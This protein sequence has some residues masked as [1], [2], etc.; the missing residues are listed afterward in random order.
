MAAA[1]PQRVEDWRDHELVRTNQAKSS[2]DQQTI[3]DGKQRLA[4]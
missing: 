1:H 4:P 2:A 3:H